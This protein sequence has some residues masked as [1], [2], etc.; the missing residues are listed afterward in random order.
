MAS[1]PKWLNFK[2]IAGSII[3][4]YAVAA[5]F[6]LPVP[7]WTWIW[8]HQALADEFYNSRLATD[9]RIY[10]QLYDMICKGLKN[11]TPPRT[12]QLERWRELAK[13]INRVAQKL[14]RGSVDAVR[15]RC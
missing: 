5:S 11:G 3:L 6:A 4:F 14:K 9:L 13:E 2:S 15:P 10:H 1:R 8:E 12:Q 7:R